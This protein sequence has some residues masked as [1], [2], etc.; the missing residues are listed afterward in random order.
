MASEKLTGTLK[1]WRIEYTGFEESVCYVAA[2]NRG[3]ARFVVANSMTENYWQ[4]TRRMGYSLSSIKSVRRCPKFDG[5][6]DQR[7]PVPRFVNPEV[8]EG[9]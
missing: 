2:P 4:D 1:C 9:Q 8:G 3:S 7:R 5:L 6:I